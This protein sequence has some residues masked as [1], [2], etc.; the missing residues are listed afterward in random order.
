MV[1]AVR[2]VCMVKMPVD[3]VVDVVSVRDPGVSAGVV[4]H[5]IRGVAGAR[6]RRRACGGIGRI[7]GDGTLVE[8]AIQ[9]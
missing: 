4:V 5:M 9:Q 8:V 1:V 6:V 2:T 3:Q 7:D